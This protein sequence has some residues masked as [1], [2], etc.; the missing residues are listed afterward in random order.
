MTFYKR[1]DETVTSLAMFVDDNIARVYEV[2]KEPQLEAE[3]FRAIYLIIYMLACKQSLYKNWEQLDDFAMYGAKMVYN[4]MVNPKQFVPDEKGKKLD[5]IKSVLNYINVSMN[6]MKNHFQKESFNLII[7]PETD[8][9]VDGQ[10][11]LESIYSGIQQDYDFGRDEAIS[12]SFELIPSIAKKV[13]AETPFKNNKLISKNL[14]LSILLTLLNNVTLP[15]STLNKIEKATDVD[16]VHSTAY[17]VLTKSYYDSVILW[18]LDKS[19][20]GYVDM[21][22]RKVKI[23]FSKNLSSTSSDFDLNQ[24]VLDAIISTAFENMYNN[25]ED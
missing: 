8:D 21:L 10:A 1:D 15:N 11:I 18:H 4:R 2:G 24:N 6:G 23:R 16:I 25:E 19:Y 12:D 20:T 9:R 3:I 5:L 22:T 17:R 7:D 14:Y 13:V